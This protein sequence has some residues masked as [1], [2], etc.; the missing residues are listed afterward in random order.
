MR[1]K[2]FPTNDEIMGIVEEVTKGKRHK[3]YELFRKVIR[4]LNKLGYYDN[5]VSVKRVWRIYRKI[6]EKD[7]QKV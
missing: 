7:V 2:R 5:H 1:R 4:K 6:N 3:P